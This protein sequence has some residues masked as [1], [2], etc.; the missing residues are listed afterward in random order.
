MKH[1]IRIKVIAVCFLCLVTSV[2]SAESRVSILTGIDDNPFRLT[3]SLNP[4]QGFF[5][6]TRLDYD[7]RFKNGLSVDFSAKLTEFEARV[8]DASVA[9]WNFGSG[10]RYKLSKK[11][12]LDLNLSAGELDKTY[13]SRATGRVGVFNNQSI[14]DRYDYSWHAF[15]A[16]Y[17]HRLNKKHRL[18]LT[19]QFYDRD[20]FDYSS[21]NLTNFDYKR[22]G[23]E[24]DWRYRINK[25]WTLY[26]DYRVRTRAFDS[27]EART[28]Q[29]DIILGSLLEYQYH[30]MSATT[31]WDVSQ[32]TRLSMQVFNDDKQDNSSGYY[33]TNFS[34]YSVSWRR[35][36]TEDAIIT[37]RLKYQNYENKNN[38]LGNEFEE[39]LDT[40]DNRGFVLNFSFRKPLW[41][42]DNNTVHGY[43]RASLYHFKAKQDIYEYNRQLVEVGVR[44]RF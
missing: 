19:G 13:I 4:K 37:A 36:T 16:K 39:E 17:Q 41:E 25:S 27:R 21:L 29:G 5:L 12:R 38:I 30:R 6:S 33:D 8:K 1:L 10:Y 24:L 15:Q 35:K 42:W 11:S 40:N 7:N 28:L 14:A 3:N 26:T 9:R 31:R 43:F 34:G 20:Y 23:L 32:E 2:V 44:A 18:T 22:A